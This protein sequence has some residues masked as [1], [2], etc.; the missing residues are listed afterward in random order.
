MKREVRQVTPEDVKKIQAEQVRM[1]EFKAINL[2]SSDSEVSEAAFDPKKIG[3]KMADFTSATEQSGVLAAS[4]ALFFPSIRD[5]AQKEHDNLLLQKKS[6]HSWYRDVIDPTPKAAE[7]KI[8]YDVL[9][10]FASEGKDTEIKEADVSWYHIA[11]DP[12]K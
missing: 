5:A 6:D 11:V 2:Y 9:D 7:R 3:L 8:S 12:G 4:R 1:K 10:N